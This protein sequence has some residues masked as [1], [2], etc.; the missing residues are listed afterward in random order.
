MDPIAGKLYVEPPLIRE[1]TSPSTMAIRVIIPRLSAFTEHLDL[2]DSG[3]K[4]CEP[5]L[6]L[7]HII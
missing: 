7:G 4:V 6:A 3:V 5:E 2:E 1:G